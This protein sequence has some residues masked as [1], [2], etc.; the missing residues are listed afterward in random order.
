M[1]RG[2]HGLLSQSFATD[3]LVKEAALKI[4]ASILL[5]VLSAN[6]LVGCNDHEENQL[7]ASSSSTAKFIE[8]HLNLFSLD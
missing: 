7:G 5:G 2:S 1:S 3:E 4:L 8:V 6:W